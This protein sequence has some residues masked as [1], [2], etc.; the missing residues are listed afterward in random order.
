MDIFQAVWDQA[1]R[2]NDKGR[3]VEAAALTLAANA[4]AQE[5]D[6]IKKERKTWRKM[7][8]KSNTSGTLATFDL[9]PLEYEACRI[10][11]PD[12]RHANWEAK[13]KAWQWILKQPWAKDFRASPFEK[14]RF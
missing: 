12:L 3:M 4:K 8:R 5:I 6:L 1:K 13:Q 10:M 14:V 11:C 2:S 9:H 7:L